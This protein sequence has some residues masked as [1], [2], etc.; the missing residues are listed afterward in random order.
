MMPRP[1][2]QNVSPDLKAGHPK[3]LRTMGLGALIIYG[4]G[5]MLG[6]GVYAL[7]GKVAGIMG[8]AIWMAYVIAMIA[9]GLTALS[10]ASLGS[11]YP[12]AGGSALFAHRAFGQPFLT[13]LIGLAVVASGL[14]SM[15]AQSHGFA[16]YFYYLLHEAPAGTPV[17]MQFT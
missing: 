13:Y 2:G 9:A 14:T 11:R 5:D 8:N 1:M 4:V 15:A 12:K 10:Y 7:V 6:S 3:L 17:P 16:R